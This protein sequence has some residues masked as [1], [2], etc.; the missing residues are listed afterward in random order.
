[1]P[2]PEPHQPG[3][4]TQADIPQALGIRNPAFNVH[5]HNSGNQG[6]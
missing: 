6:G 3:Q 1:M 4:I 2:K 5:P